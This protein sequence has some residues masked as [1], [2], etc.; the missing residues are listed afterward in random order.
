MPELPTGTIT[1]LFTD[2][3]GGGRAPG[4]PLGAAPRGDA[5]GPRSPRRAGGRFAGDWALEAA[6]PACSDPEE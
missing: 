5:P 2:I 6:E 1:F 3:E 4:P